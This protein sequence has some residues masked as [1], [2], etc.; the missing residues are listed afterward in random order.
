MEK[1]SIIQQLCS[2]GPLVHSPVVTALSHLYGMGS[3]RC[4]P[5][6]VSP[7]QEFR[8][9]QL[10]SIAHLVHRRLDIIIYNKG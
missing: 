8:P 5:E 7:E 6:G 9:V 1:I 2:L 4:E 10:D 3:Q